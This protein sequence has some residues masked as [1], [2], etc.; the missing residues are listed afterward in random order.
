[1][2]PAGETATDKERVEFLE[3][4]LNQSNLDRDMFNAQLHMAVARLG[5]LVEGN[6]TGRHNF[7]QRIDALIEI[8][9]DYNRM[10]REMSELREIS[11]AEAHCYEREINRLRAAP[12][13]EEL[14]EGARLVIKAWDN[15]AD[16]LDIAAMTKGIEAL[17]SALGRKES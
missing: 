4:Q 10:S 16:F 17:R 1:M 15:A 9:T 2:N 14:E 11:A 5:G 13:V 6:P 3:A 8:E 7:L 12:S